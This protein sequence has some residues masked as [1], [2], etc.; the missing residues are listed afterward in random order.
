MTVMLGIH[1]GGG[2]GLSYAGL[3]LT[4][5]LAITGVSRVMGG[6]AANAFRLTKMV[7]IT[8]RNDKN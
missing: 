5:F 2:L 4:P 6:I 1:Y 3:G 7:P 8:F